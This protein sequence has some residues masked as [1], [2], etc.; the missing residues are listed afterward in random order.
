MW[1]WSKPLRTPKL[2]PILRR[3]ARDRGCRRAGYQAHQ[4]ERWPRQGLQAEYTVFGRKTILPAIHSPALHEGR[5]VRRHRV[6]SGSRCRASGYGC[7]VFMQSDIVNFQ[8][9]GWRSEVR[10]PRRRA[11]QECLPLRSQHSESRRARDA[12]LQ[13]GTQNNLAVVRRRWTSSTSFRANGRRNQRSLP[14]EY[15]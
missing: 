12:V 15:R 7:A 3:S 6:L 10:R 5:G 13:K 11:S 14:H 9:Q 2:V 4:L 1:R 8:R